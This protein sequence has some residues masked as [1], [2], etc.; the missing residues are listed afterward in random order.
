MIL[1]DWRCGKHGIFEGSHPI[2]PAMGCDSSDV[3]KVFL[4]P[5]GSRSDATRRF[6]A[7]LRENARRYGLPD[8]RSARAGEAAYGGKTGDGLLWGDAVNQVVKPGTNFASLAAAAQA[9]NRY[10][11]PD[12]SITSVP[13]GMRLAATEVGVTKRALPR[14]ERIVDPRDVGRKAA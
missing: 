7:G 12:G 1:H 8:I 3:V 6:D 10:R 4:K 9:S 2:C 5:P 13:N 14:A 11:M